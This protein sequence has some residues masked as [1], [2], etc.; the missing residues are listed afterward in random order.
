MSIDSLFK[1]TKNSFQKSL[2]WFQKETSSIRGGRVTIELIDEVLVEYY[3]QK[4]KLKEIASLSLVNN[5]TISVEPWDKSSISNI[6]KA[7]LNSELGGSIRNDGQRVFFSFPMQSS[8]DKEKMTKI[9]KQ[10]MEKAKVSLRQVRDE[11]WK[12]IQEM[13]RKGEISE[14]EKFKQKE[15][16]QKLI[17]EFEEKIEEVE[18]RKEKEILT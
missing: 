1:E 16:L 8:E 11:A 5:R 2:D 17:D 9:L 14:D 3:E 7:L 18:E 12:K 13:E 4:L 15:N 10:K 6:E